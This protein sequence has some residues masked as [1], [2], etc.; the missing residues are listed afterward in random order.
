MLSFVYYVLFWYEKH[1]EELEIE[2]KKY[3]IEK[4]L[5]KDLGFLPIMACMLD[6]AIFAK[7]FCDSPAEVRISA[8]IYLAQIN[9]IQL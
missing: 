4:R 6:F 9:C 7:Y 2:K 5:Q 1:K 3:R 8:A